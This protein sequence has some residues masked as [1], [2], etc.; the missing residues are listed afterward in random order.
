MEHELHSGIQVGSREI[1]AADQIGFGK[2]AFEPADPLQGD[3]L[4]EWRIGA[5]DAFQPF[6]HVLNIARARVNPTR[7]SVG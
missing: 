1:G 4:R 6:A 3:P 2:H 7:G 5:K